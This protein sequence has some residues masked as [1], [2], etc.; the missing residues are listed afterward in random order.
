MATQISIVNDLDMLLR[1]PSKVSKELVEKSCLC[2]AS[3]IYAAKAAGEQQTTV[4]IGIGTLSVNLL[5][6]Q[7][8][9]IPSKNLKQSIKDALTGNSDPIEVELERAFAEKLLMACDEV[10]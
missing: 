5:D 6:M 10:L 3:A 2:I 8:K 9:F 1:L 4:N 7:C